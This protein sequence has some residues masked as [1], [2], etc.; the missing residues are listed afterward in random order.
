MVVTIKTYQER[1]EDQLMELLQACFEEKSVR[2]L[3]NRAHDVYAAMVGTELA[4]I[5]FSWSNSFHPFCTYIRI[6]CHPCYRH[7]QV[8]EKL[9]EKA[10]DNRKDSLP[11]QTSIWETS[12]SLKELYTKKGF[13]EIRRTYMT[14]LKVAH[15]VEHPFD[16]SENA[17]LKTLA[18]IEANKHLTDELAG[19]V[20]RHYEE[21][22]LDNP[23][24]HF[25]VSEWKDM[26]FADDVMKNGSY[27][28]VDQSERHIAA[29]SFLHE[30][31]QENFVELGWFGASDD[32][33]LIL[34]IIQQQI[35]DS[36]NNG[37]ELITGEFD[38]TSTYAMNVLKH[39]PF[40]PSPTW[41]TY[42][43]T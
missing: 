36:L 15:V 4:G 27:V 3:M 1:N 41:I 35:L 14:T 33:A 40:A 18:D 43:L 12:V 39:F 10:L 38:T 21:T 9:V 25:S 26:I 23:V 37:I 32:E 42:R 28:L 13:K 22:H 8:E 11:L 30:G 20:K 19:L 17:E 24:A 31:S 29:Y 7:L 5:V 6:L 2:S 16:R 34:P